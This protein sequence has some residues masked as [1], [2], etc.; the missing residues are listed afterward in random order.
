V[1]GEKSEP[2]GESMIALTADRDRLE[3]QR[4]LRQLAGSYHSVKDAIRRL[5]TLL[6][7]PENR[8]KKLWYGERA[9]I[10]NH[11]FEHVRRKLQMARGAISNMQRAASTDDIQAQ[12]ADV[13][14]RMEQLKSAIERMSR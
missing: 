4:L 13:L 3:M 14:A 12:F 6:G 8:I 2:N 7:W 11:E 10:A 5:M 1:S 9:V